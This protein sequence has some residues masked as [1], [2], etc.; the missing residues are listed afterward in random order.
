MST[1][2]ANNVSISGGSISGITDLAI[3]DG[4]TGASTLAAANIPYVVYRGNLTVTG[5]TGFVS[6]VPTAP[7]GSYLV[8]WY[9]RVTTAGDV[10]DCLALRTRHYDGGARTTPVYSGN[11]IIDYTF[12]GT[13]DPADFFVDATTIRGSYSQPIYHDDATKSLDYNCIF[14]TLSGTPSISVRITVE[15]LGT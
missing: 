7:V 10:G 15:Y 14:N 13:A 6:M 2:A 3:A 5:S 4:G 8:H 9:W 1:Q 11:S 12:N